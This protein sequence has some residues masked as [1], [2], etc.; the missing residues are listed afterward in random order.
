MGGCPPDCLPVLP[1]QTELLI[2]AQLTARRSNSWE[3]GQL[4]KMQSEETWSKTSSVS[5]HQLFK[6]A[7]RGDFQLNTRQMILGKNCSVDPASLPLELSLIL[8]F[9]LNSYCTLSD[10][11]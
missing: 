2:T 10:L 3:L 5:L 6:P 9:P 4:A 1:H 8:L 7:G 11:N